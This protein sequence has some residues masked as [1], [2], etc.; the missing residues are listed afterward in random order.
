MSILLILSKNSANFAALREISHHA[1]TTLGLRGSVTL[2]KTAVK[3]GA[4]GSHAPCHGS[5]LALSA[6]VLRLVRGV[7]LV[8]RGTLLA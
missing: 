8:E 6:A 7:S 4:F 3:R 5:V 2:C 1:F